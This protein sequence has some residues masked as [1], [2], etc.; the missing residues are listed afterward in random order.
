MKIPLGMS[1]LTK[2]SEMISIGGSEVLFTAISSH[3]MLLYIV[4]KLLV[5]MT[6]WLHA[7][8]RPRFAD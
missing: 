5:Y 7:R 2:V 6:T 1:D 8:H 4:T 3:Y